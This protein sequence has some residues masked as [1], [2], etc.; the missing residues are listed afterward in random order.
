LR[1]LLGDIVNA[2][3]QEVASRKAALPFDDLARA[4]LARKPRGDRFVEALSRRDRISVIAECKHRSPAKGVLRADY[5]PAAIARRYQDAG[6]AA[7][8][9]L[10][11]K[12]FFDGSLAHLERVRAAVNL[13]LLRK[14]FIVDEYQLLEARASGADAVLLIVAVLERSV[15]CRLLAGA[16][17]QG[18]AAL[19]EVH[20]TDEAARALDAG[21]VIVGVNNRDLR[22]LEVRLD[23]SERL[24]RLL[25]RTVVKVSESGIRTRDDIRWLREWG[26][27][28]ALI[29]ERLVASPDPGAALAELIENG[30]SAC[31]PERAAQ[32]RED[33]PLLHGGDG[34]TCG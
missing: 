12:A 11:E 15:L 1:I 29:G 32:G 27:D 21:A 22:T 14:D 13:P 24:A 3:R 2:A 19:V 7:V 4:A 34:R 8:S 17:S 23:T 18:L 25:P 6:A 30:G 10:T 20:D 28:A 9:V 5:D 33:P 31:P 26:Y 16:R